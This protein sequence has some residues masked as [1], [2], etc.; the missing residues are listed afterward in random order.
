V[1]VKSTDMWHA[2]KRAEIVAV[3]LVSKA[4]F[5]RGM[6]YTKR[7]KHRCNSYVSMHACRYIDDIYDDCSKSNAF[8][9]MILAARSEV[10]VGGMAVE[11]EPNHQY[12]FTGCC[13]VTG[14]SRGIV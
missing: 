10:N 11:I 13:H 9:F 1:T 14:A 5:P 2:S 8:Y 6:G 4:C 3:S 7:K 12:S